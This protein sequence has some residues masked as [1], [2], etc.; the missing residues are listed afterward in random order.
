MKI[1]I[2][3]HYT[4]AKNLSNSP[5]IVPFAVSV[6]NVNNTLIYFRFQFFFPCSHNYFLIF[7][8]TNYFR[9]A[10]LNLLAFPEF[11]KIERMKRWKNQA[12]CS[13]CLCI[14]CKIFNIIAAIYKM[15]PLLFNYSMTNTEFSKVLVTPCSMKIEQMHEA[16]EESYFFSLT[17]HLDYILHKGRAIAVIV[18]TL[19]APTMAK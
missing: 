2:G 10:P 8:K 19:I 17:A 5:C 7:A 13:S 18:I 3:K 16:S 11:N 14:R 1:W 4:F 6:C 9:S 15:H 12:V